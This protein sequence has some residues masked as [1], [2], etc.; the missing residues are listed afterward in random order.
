MKNYKPIDLS[1]IKTYPLK[2]RSSKVRE[3]D[4]ASTHQKGKSFKNF[5][6]ALPHI[7][8]AKDF[9]EVTA[10]V[11]DACRKQKPVIWA[12]GAHSIK[13]G[14]NPILIDLMRRG[15][16]RVLALNGAGIVHDFELAMIGQTSEDV[17]REI[18]SGMF[19]MAKETG[20]MINNAIREYG[21]E[22]TGAAVGKMLSEQK[23][24]F[25]SQ[26]LLATG[27]ELGIPVTV[28]TA[29]GTDIIHMHPSADGAAIG[30]ASHYDFRLLAS[31]VADLGGGG[32]FFNVGSAVILPEVF[33]K[34]VT[35]VRNQG[36]LLE[37]FTT[38]NMDFIQHYRPMTNV[39]K[40]P[41]AGCGRGFCLT[42]HH[43]IMIPLLAAAVIESL[44]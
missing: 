22:G 37:D 41:T 14:L 17:D 1:N 40:R 42:G 24:P 7:L 18:A 44:P 8:A 35:L 21:H 36:V 34:A 2:S 20:E 27:Y 13:C 4:F 33:L 28:H 6:D 26:S 9:H 3:A 16:I 38:V 12:M 31:A 39:V 30:R 25:V 23:P 29:I 10:A 11:V 19:G 43:E 5:L 32:V 15:V